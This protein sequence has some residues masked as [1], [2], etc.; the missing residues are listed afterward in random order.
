MPDAPGTE[1]LAQDLREAHGDDA[2]LGTEFFRGTGAINV[3]PGT[4]GA[5][6]ETLRAKGFKHLMSVHG[7][8]YFPEEPRLGVQYELLDRDALDR[9]TIKLRV[10]VDAPLVPSVTV[11]WPTANH[12]EREVYDMFGVLFEGHPD[13]RRILMPEDYEGH[14]QRRDFPL[15]GEP[16]LFTAAETAGKDY[17]IG[18]D[19]QA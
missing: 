10:P 4:I 11:K 19:G 15:G 13:L 7:L 3:A 18:I 5:V 6:L 17:T 1:L 12:Q 16:V 8:D 9:L 2:V 14:P